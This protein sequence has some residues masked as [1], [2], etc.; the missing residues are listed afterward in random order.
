LLS[1]WSQNFDS[2]KNMNMNKNK[3]KKILHILT[4]HAMQGCGLTSLVVGKIVI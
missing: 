3:N 1:H 4:R 2:T